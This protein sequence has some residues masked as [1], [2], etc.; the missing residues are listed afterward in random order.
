MSLSLFSPRSSSPSESKKPSWRFFS[1]S[2][3]PPVPTLPTQ[4]IPSPPRLRTSVSASAIPLSTSARGHYRTHSSLAK[5]TPASGTDFS[6]TLGSGAQVVRTPSEARRGIMKVR[7]KAVPR[8]TIAQSADLPM[9]EECDRR[10]S[11]SITARAPSSAPLGTEKGLHK[12]SC[13][14]TVGNRD[15]DENRK[16]SRRS[17]I[18]PSSARDSERTHRATFIPPSIPTSVPTQT[19]VPFSAALLDITQKPAPTSS[20]QI[21]VKLE[22]GFSLDERS[23]T[24]TITLPYEILQRGGGLLG[25]FVQGH[26]E[27][28][29]DRADQAADEEDRIRIVS[30]VPSF[31]SKPGMTDGDSAS[32]SDLDS[33]EYG[34]SALLR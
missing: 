24:S 23:N 25:R 6:P 18:I 13:M 1:S 2:T 4:P 34:S 5:F 17:H 28:M 11:L 10:V 9:M 7:Q 30:D 31:G 8:P 29:K 3:A 14:A 12:S 19:T 26:L 32:E 16:S 22:S 21:L 33:E 15:R 27:E 20:D